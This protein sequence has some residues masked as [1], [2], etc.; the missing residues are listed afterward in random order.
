[1]VFA[2]FFIY[3]KNGQGCHHEERADHEEGQHDQVPP[4]G[5]HRLEPPPL[6]LLLP[7]L[8]LELDAGAREHVEEQDVPERGR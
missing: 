1:M 6:A 7:A 5:Q 4:A 2:C 3:E 8:V